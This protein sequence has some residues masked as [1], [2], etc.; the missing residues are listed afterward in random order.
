MF[1]YMDYYIYFLY[2]LCLLDNR[3]SIHIQVCIQSKDRQ[4]I[5]VSMNK[6]RLGRSRLH[7]KVMA[8][9]DLLVRVL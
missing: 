6:H 1:Q 8:N 5:L 7:R 9:M 3:Y 4:N 2:K